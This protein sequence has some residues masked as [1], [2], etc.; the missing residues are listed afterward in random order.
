M[1]KFTNTRPCIPISW[2]ISGYRKFLLI[3]LFI[4]SWKQFLNWFFSTSSQPGKTGTSSITAKGTS[5]ISSSSSITTSST[6]II[7]SR[8]VSV[9]SIMVS[10]TSSSS[11]TIS[12]S[13]GT[14]TGGGGGGGGV[15]ICSVSGI[16]SS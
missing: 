14:C 6:S 1:I 13:V 5:I 10:S 2:A 4:C 15:L 12:I 8:S 3:C 9:D 7:S 16:S 11:S